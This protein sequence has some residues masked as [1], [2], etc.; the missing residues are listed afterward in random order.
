MMLSSSFLVFPAFPEF[1][2]CFPEIVCFFDTNKFFFWFIISGIGHDLQFDPLS[3]KVLEDELFPRS[4]LGM[5]STCH[6]KVMSLRWSPGCR[7]LYSWV[8]WVRCLHGTWMGMGLTHW[9]LVDGL[10]GCRSCSIC[11]STDSSPQYPYHCQWC[12]WWQ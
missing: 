6:L 11:L 10:L 5:D 2:L 9:P 7:W 8:K 3:L 1:Q 4:S 12:G